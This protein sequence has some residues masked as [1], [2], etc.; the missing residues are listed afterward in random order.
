MGALGGGAPLS[1]VYLAH[2]A[3]SRSSARVAASARAVRPRAKDCIRTTP[4]SAR[5]AAPRTCRPR[6]LACSTL[7]AAWRAAAA[8]RQRACS[9]AT[10]AARERHCTWRGPMWAEAL[11]GT[12]RPWHEATWFGLGVGE[13]S[14]LLGIRVRVRVGFGLGLGVRV[15]VGVGVSGRRRP[16]CAAQRSFVA[17]SSAVGATGGASPMRGARCTR[18]ARR[19]GAPRPATTPPS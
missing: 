11:R 5:R 13:T 18:R 1:A 4:R 16:Q 19:G 17:R 10:L 2:A 6:A 8:R 15:R 7:A 12:K 14:G 3:P 9:S